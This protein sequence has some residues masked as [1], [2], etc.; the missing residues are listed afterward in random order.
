MLRNMPIRRKLM[1]SILSTSIVVML[2]MSGAFFA[3]QYLSLRRITLVELSTVGTLTAENATAAL[4]LGDLQ[5]AR[6][7]LSGLKAQ[8]HLVAAAIYDRTGAVVAKFPSALTADQLPQAPGAP[9]YRFSGA[10]LDGFVAIQQDGNSRGALYL[11]VDSDAILHDWLRGLLK[12]VTLVM[13]LVLLVA[14]AFAYVLQ[15]HLALPILE[16]AATAGKVSREHDYSVRAA[17]RGNDELGLLTDAF[18]QMLAQIQEQHQALARSESRLTTIINNLAEGLVVSDMTGKLV[19]FNRAAMELLGFA[20]Q[21]EVQ[22]F[23]FI[24]EMVDI[25]EVS[26]LEGTVLGLEQWPVSRILRGESLHN[27]ELRT[28]IKHLGWH[29]ILNYGGMLVHDPD[30]RPTLAVLVMSDITERKRDEAELREAKQSLEL[31]VTERTVELLAAKERA[32]SSDRLKSEFLANMSHELRTPLNAIIGFTGTL[33]MKLPGPLNADQEKQL[34]TVRHSARH[35]LSLINDLLDVAK[36]EA[37]RTELVLTSA[38]CT[39]VLEEVVT[40]LRPLAED[41]GLEFLVEMPPQDIVLQTDR[42]ALN[43]ILINLVNNAI[44]FT[45]TGQ[46]AVAVAVRETEDGKIVDIS[47]SD[48][49]CGIKPADMARLFQAF[50]QVDSSSTRRYEGTGLGLHL[51]QML[52]ELIGARI[53]CESRFG[54]GSTF[55]LSIRRAVPQQPVADV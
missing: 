42:R 28:H 51:S 23:V 12:I 20:S 45:D 32:E 46:V 15:K 49:G 17:K 37:G 10:Y 7:A 47:V 52:A 43:Q 34:A 16:L 26:T 14:Y 55:T 48:T 25:F 18:N 33:L 27:L 1:L 22:R 29:R 39:S 4:V 21:Q 40:A 6:R 19:T 9:G 50:S 54:D 11:K 31:K 36:I 53:T 2:L 41:K 38:S 8:Q 24:A 3:H 13:L 5:G 35:L 44:K 30:G